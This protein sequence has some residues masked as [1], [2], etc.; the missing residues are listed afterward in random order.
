[1]VLLP[2]AAPRDLDPAQLPQWLVFTADAEA[3]RAGAW[4]QEYYRLEVRF[5]PESTPR[6]PICWADKPVF[7]YRRVR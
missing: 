1:M 5:P 3:T 4:W 2:A 6:S 7:V